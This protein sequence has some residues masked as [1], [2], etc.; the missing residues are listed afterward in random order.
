MSLADNQQ[1]LAKKPPV[2][3]S[4]VI[5]RAKRRGNLLKLRGLIRRSFLTPRN[6]SLKMS[7]F[8]QTLDNQFSDPDNRYHSVTFDSISFE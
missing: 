6:D 2:C 5:A 4:S 3:T 8:V 1:C 7:I